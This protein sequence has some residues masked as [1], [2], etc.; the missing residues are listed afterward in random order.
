M[1]EEIGSAEGGQ[2]K[3]EVLVEFLKRTADGEYAS[4]ERISLPFSRIG[5]RTLLDQIDEAE[6]YY[7]GLS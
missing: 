7:Y 2:D 5:E 4:V 1:K 3:I 6:H